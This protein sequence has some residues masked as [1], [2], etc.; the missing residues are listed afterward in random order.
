MEIIL[1]ADERLDSLE[2]KGLKI[3]QSRELYRF[4]SDAVLLANSVRAGKKD[5]VID[6]G[7]GSG[8]VG[9]LIAAK[10]GASVIGI[11][12]QTAL[13]DAAVRS[14]E[15]NGMTDS[16]K[17]FNLDIKNLFSGSTEESGTEQNAEIKTD[18][19]EQ[20]IGVQTDEIKQ[21]TEIK[22]DDASL[23]KIGGFDIA[24]SNPPFG[25]KADA[26]GIINESERIAR[27]EDKITLSEIVA[28]AARSLRFGGAF[29]VV[30]KALRLSEALYLMTKYGVE[31]KELTLVVPTQ[32]KPP[33][34]CIVRG[35]RGG[36]IGLKIHKPLIVFDENGEYTREVKKM[37]DIKS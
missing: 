16:L 32:K 11:E 33:D 28:A 15:L 5:R 30:V 3:I 36:K 18:E 31:P 6:L 2:Y 23:L 8:V 10:T 24:V 9:T 12:L 20:N 27:T 29:Y 14:A 25:K 17:F 19:T 37:Y 1:K 21:N 26:K 7:S 13:F 4:T 35:I 34:A 22:T